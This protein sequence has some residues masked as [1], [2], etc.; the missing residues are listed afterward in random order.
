[1][2]KSSKLDETVN[3]VKLYQHYV[4]RSEVPA[5][6]HLWGCLSIMAA[7]VADRVWLEKFSG[8]RLA[9]NLY[10]VLLGPSGLGKGIA[11]DLATSFVKDVARVNMYRG[12][13]TGP[14]LIDH[15]GRKRKLL[16]GARVLDSPKMFLV[17]PELA[18]SVGSGPMADDFVKL[19][20]ELYTGG[21]YLF[22]AGTRTHGHVTIRGHCMNWL[23]GSTKEWF[24]HA[25]T[26]D[27]VEGGA[28]ARIILVPGE[29]NF[30]VRYTRPLLPLDRAFIREHLQARAYLLS[31]TEGP[32]VMT[33]DAKEIEDTWYHGRAVPTDDAL[34]PTWRRQHDLSLKLAMLLALADG[35][36]LVITKRHM[37]AARDLAETTTLAVPDIITMASVPKESSGFIFV[38]D[39][40]AKQ[41]RIQRTLLTNKC[42]RRG[43]TASRIDECM[44]TLIAGK[45]V[46]VEH[47]AHGTTWYVWAR[48]R[49][50]LD[51]VSNITE[52]GNEEEEKAASDG[53]GA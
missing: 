7:C 17:T 22:Q 45:D 33:D 52:E 2:S 46:K 28:L 51:A 50:M 48:K 47:G 4:G 3:F 35:G 25:L 32:V 43:I 34:I 24:V 6:Y 49:R 5:Q 27:S 26:R 20:T 44:R 11:I 16:T 30:N 23:G 9:P 31:Q 53:G 18:M 40:I 19:M 15:M 39:L 21:E 1:M 38:R 10:T 42:S 12:K 37:I 41:G 8:S 14:F 36:D 13:S 29:Y